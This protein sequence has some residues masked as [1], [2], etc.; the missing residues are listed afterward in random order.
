MSQEA[1]G[2]KVGS[3]PISSQPTLGWWDPPRSCSS[4]IQSD[5]KAMQPHLPPARCEIWAPEVCSLAL[6]ISIIKAI[7]RGYDLNQARTL[8]KPP[9]VLKASQ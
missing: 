6:A 1:L 8:E 9:V 4:C 2:G 5:N 3:H 7:S